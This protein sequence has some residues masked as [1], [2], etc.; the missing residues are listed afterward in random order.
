METLFDLDNFTREDLEML[1]REVKDKLASLR[2]HNLLQTIKQE[3]TEKG[4]S[5][6]PGCHDDIPDLHKLDLPYYF[7]IYTWDYERQEDIHVS[8]RDCDQEE[9]VQQLNFEYQPQDDDDFEIIEEFDRD[10]HDSPFRAKVKLMIPVY[11]RCLDKLP[12]RFKAIFEDGN[13]EDALVKNGI[14]Y[15]ND[16]E[17]CSLGDHDY[18]IVIPV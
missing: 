12:L 7:N 13:V 8:D 6:Q 1:E 5:C 11:Y 15:I 2:H 16:E 4:Y 18:F 3:V 9:W 14:I 17:I 10:A